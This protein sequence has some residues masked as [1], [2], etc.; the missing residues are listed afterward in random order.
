MVNTVIYSNE[1][2]LL[3]KNALNIYQEKSL[4]YLPNDGELEKITFTEKLE[5]KMQ[6]LIKAQKKPYYNM[7]NSV[8][9]RAA[10]V[11]VAVIILVTMMSIT[12]IGETFIRFIVNTYD[13]HSQVTFEEGSEFNPETFV[14]YAPEFVPDGYEITKKESELNI[15]NIIQY[16]NENGAVL[17]YEQFPAI[18]HTLVNTEN[19]VI[20]K[21]YV[22]EYEAMYWES[23]EIRYILFVD[24]TYSYM[25]SGEY[26]EISRE[27][28]IKVA[29]SVKPEK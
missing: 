21:T 22:N 26:N 3:L 27:E 17:D 24:E 16:T 2:E 8:S 29:E 7:T 13:D 12:A 1:N 28:I 23:S 10:C 6:K 25:I 4:S 20:E 5:K 11:L 18:G 15:Y 9:K 14:P 19:A